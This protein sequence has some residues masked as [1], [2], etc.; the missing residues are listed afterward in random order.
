MNVVS[1]V[2]AMAVMIPTGSVATY[3]EIGRAL[4]IGPRQAGRAVATLH[5][6]VLGWRV[7]HA[8]GTPATC[9]AGEPQAL[10]EAE[11]V[12]FGSKPTSATR[13]MVEGNPRRCSST[14]E[15]VPA[16]RGR[17]SWHPGSSRGCRWRQGHFD[18]VGADPHR[19]D[20]HRL[21]GRRAGGDAGGEVEARAVQPALDVTALDISLGQLHVAVTARRARRRTRR[22]CGQDRL[23]ARPGRGASPRRRPTGPAWLR[24]LPPTAPT[25]PGG[26]S[27]SQRWVVLG[28]T[29]TPRSS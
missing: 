26:L 20:G 16:A 18:A 4:G 13:R 14:R 6:E 8:D 5:D 9:H 2:R 28:R 1:E 17:Q 29:W 27:R 24:V 12:P 7:V 21:G 25:L 10:L 23:G 15:W 11:G 19:I 22:H 3:G